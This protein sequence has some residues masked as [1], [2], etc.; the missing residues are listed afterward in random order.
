MEHNCKSCKNTNTQY[1]PLAM[2]ELHNGAMERTIKRLWIIIIILIGLLCATN[3]AWLVYESQFEEV[4]TTEI[5]ARQDTDSG[6][7]N[8]FV[9]GDMN[10]VTDGQI[11]EDNDPEAQDGR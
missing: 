7:N 2:V 6:G 1:I 4:T 8:Y 5:E 3:F 11:Q 10:G 9:G